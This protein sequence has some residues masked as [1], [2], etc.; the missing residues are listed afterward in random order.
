MS[1][2]NISRLYFEF[3]FTKMIIFDS[4]EIKKIQDIYSN[5]LND[6]VVI[7]SLRKVIY[8]RHEANIYFKNW[9]ELDEIQKI[10][11]FLDKKEN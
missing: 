7:K 4:K 10:D 3:N 9:L 8:Q 2:E 6:Q 11:F 5:I 1:V